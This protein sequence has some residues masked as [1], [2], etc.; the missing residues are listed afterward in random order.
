MESRSYAWKNKNELPNQI[1]KLREYPQVQGSVFFSSSTFASNPNGWSDSLRNNYYKYPA[2][3]PPMAWI[4]SV[5]PAR[6][7]MLYDSSKVAIY[8]NA[9]NLYFKEDSNNV[10]VNRYVIYN[11]AD[12]S[13]IDINDPKNITDIIISGNNYYSFSLQNIPVDQNTIVIASTALTETNNESVLSRY[14]YLVRK[15]NGWHVAFIRNN[16]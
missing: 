5:R 16:N 2:I 4:D 12:T 7:V 9:I 15:S 10:K 6:P 11:F 13:Y 3:I 1:K 8:S 14:I